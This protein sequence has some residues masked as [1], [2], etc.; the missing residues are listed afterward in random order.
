[1]KLL[2]FL[3]YGVLVGLASSQLDIGGFDKRKNHAKFNLADLT[4]AKMAFW[5]DHMPEVAK[6]L[7]RDPV[8]FAKSHYVNAAVANKTTP[9]APVL[10]LV[11]IICPMVQNRIPGFNCSLTT[12]QILMTTLL[13]TMGISPH[14]AT[15]IGFGFLGNLLSM[16][17]LNLYGSLADENNFA[18]RRKFH[19]NNEFCCG[20]WDKNRKKY[21]FCN[22][23]G[24][25]SL[26]R[27][28]EK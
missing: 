20:H 23:S 8:Q 24:E 18:I 17:I 19:N 11:Q 16:N 1:M 7:L 3:T 25:N 26:F 15:D 2:A 4:K 13:E 12:L 9:G 27:Q 5:E 10:T 6:E 21:L 28:A 14:C 22:V